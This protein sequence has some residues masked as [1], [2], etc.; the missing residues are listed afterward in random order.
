MR[1]YVQELKSF[2]SLDALSQRSAAA[3]TGELTISDG[4]KTTAVTGNTWVT[5]D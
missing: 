4:M 5:I 1:F 3:T 2:R